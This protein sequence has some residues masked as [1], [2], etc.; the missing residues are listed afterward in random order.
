MHAARGQPR[1]GQRGQAAV[2]FMLTIPIILVLCIGMLDIGWGVFYYNT[3]S[4]CAREGAR[5]GIVLTDPYYK[6]TYYGHSP[7]DEPGNVPDIG[8][9]TASTYAG[10]T[11][12]VGRT[13]AQ[14]KG[15]DLSKLKVEIH[16]LPYGTQA[17]L[18]LPLTVTVEMPFQPLF[19]RLL[20]A[21]AV[22]LR[23][24][25]MMRTQ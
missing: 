23:A 11:T 6:N 9:Y 1:G 21:G 20:G 7:W 17:H 2:E 18:R 24:S 8:P 4:N 10:T 15:L 3:L 19:S 12:I 22:T 5:F 25:S 13:A 16:V 14:A